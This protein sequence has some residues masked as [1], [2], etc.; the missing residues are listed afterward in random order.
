MRLTYC[1]VCKTDLTNKVFY[2]LDEITRETPDKYTSTRVIF[3]DNDNQVSMEKGRWC[4]YLDTH[5]CEE[6]FGKPVVLKD[7][8]KTK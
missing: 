6:C 5:Y 7:L 4:Y 1:D 3:K 2:T 8:V